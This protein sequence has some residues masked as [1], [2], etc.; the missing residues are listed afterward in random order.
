MAV[1]TALVQDIGRGLIEVTWSGLTSVDRGEIQNLSRW[2]D[3]T[4]EVYGTFAANTL[5]LEGS[6]TTATSNLVA[7]NDPNGNPLTFTAAKAE[8]VLENPK[9]IAPRVTT[10]AVGANLVVKIIAKRRT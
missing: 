4:V 7:L 3:K 5:T 2:S 8:V 1:R 9:Y 6:M 10:G